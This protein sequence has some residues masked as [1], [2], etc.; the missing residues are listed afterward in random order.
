MTTLKCL[1]QSFCSKEETNKQTTKGAGK[2]HLSLHVNSMGLISLPSQE[3][4]QSSKLLASPASSSPD[5]VARISVL[6]LT[7]VHPEHQWKF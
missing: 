5:K 6:L 4:R 2:D 3:H 1:T 7:A